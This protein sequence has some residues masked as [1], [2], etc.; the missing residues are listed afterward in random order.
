MLQDTIKRNIL[1]EFCFSIGKV[2]KVILHPHTP[3]AKWTKNFFSK[4]RDFSSL[5]ELNRI[6]HAWTEFSYSLKQAQ[7]T[8]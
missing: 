4:S 8:F 2:G 7:K 5:D 6:T 3:G 1:E